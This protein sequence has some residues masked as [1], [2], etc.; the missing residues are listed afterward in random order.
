MAILYTHTE[1]LTYQANNVK[2]N[3]LSVIIRTLISP[4]CAKLKG[5]HFIDF[6]RKEQVVLPYE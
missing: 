2:I 4:K 6:L 5:M 3:T 1:K